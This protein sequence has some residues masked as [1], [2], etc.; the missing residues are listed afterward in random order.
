MMSGA[1]VAHGSI[2]LFQ[3]KDGFRL[4]GPNITVCNFG[5]WTNE[6]PECEVKLPIGKARGGDVPLINSANR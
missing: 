5:N 3:C 1:Q 2:G 4:V 6:A